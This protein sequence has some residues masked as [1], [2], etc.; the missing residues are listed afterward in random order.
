MQ[1]TENKT[2][3]KQNPF[4]SFWPDVNSEKGE[5]DAIKA[6]AVAMAYLVFSYVV[7]TALIIFAGQ[8]LLG[9]FA[10][11]YELIGTLAVN[12]VAILAAG[13]M[14]WVLL[15]RQN[16]IVAVIGLVWITAEVGMK[17]MMAPGRGVV[18]AILTLLFSINGVRG[19]LAAKQK[20][21]QAPKEA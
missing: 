18:I 14:A 2:Q 6:G 16:F 10:D 17:L 8:D 20:A 21:A 7:S 11:N 12:V 1:N 9:A 4:R 15:K 3:E 5:K 13:A 19:A